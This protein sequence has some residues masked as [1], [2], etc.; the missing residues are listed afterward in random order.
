MSRAKFFDLNH[1]T[2]PEGR[3]LYQEGTS[4]T[5]RQ[6]VARTAIDGIIDDGPIF[7]Q[8]YIASSPYCRELLGLYPATVVMGRFVLESHV[9]L[10]T[11]PECSDKQCGAV[12]YDRGFV[13]VSG[14]SQRTEL[15]G[16]DV[17]YEWIESTLGRIHER[18][19]DNNPLVGQR[20][21]EYLMEMYANGHHFMEEHNRIE[22]DYALGGNAHLAEVHP[23]PVS[24]KNSM[25]R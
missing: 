16:P 4:L 6:L 15:S 7:S 13:S 8:L 22:V 23:E 9:S 3:K 19:Q 17:A 14:M 5:A 2:M 25:R 18:T 10:L 20:A 12:L 21:H 11:I 24:Y 1:E